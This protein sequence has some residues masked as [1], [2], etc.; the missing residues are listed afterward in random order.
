LFWSGLLASA[1]K[2]FEAYLTVVN[3]PKL[4]SPASLPTK[5]LPARREQAKTVSFRVAFHKGAA[6][7]FSEF[8]TRGVAVRGRKS[9]ELADN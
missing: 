1:L 5:A 9:E 7:H 4:C 8:F 2:H 6:G 3:R